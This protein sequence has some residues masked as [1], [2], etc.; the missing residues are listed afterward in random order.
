MSTRPGSSSQNATGPV[1]SSLAPPGAGYLPSAV[2]LD[3]L[4]ACAAAHGRL[5]AL[6]ERLDDVLVRRQSRLPGWTVAHLLTHLARNAD[7]HT[8][9]IEAAWSGE[10]RPQYPGGAEER[11]RGIEAGADRSAAELRDDLSAA[12]A[13]LERAW[14]STHVDIWR[15]GVGRTVSGGITTIADLVFY[16][17]REVE[18]HS[19]DLGLTDVGGLDWDELSSSYVDAEWE[20]TLAGLPARVPP[21]VTVLLAPGDRPSHAAGTGKRIVPVEAPTLPILRWLTGRGGDPT[22]SALGPW[23]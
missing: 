19:F 8:G 10:I 11:A 20:W 1:T 3:R 6:V 14:D 15:T 7:S 5:A 18:I 21:E 22:W 2:P 17:W 4:A 16:R 13:R 12:V 23:V 9:M